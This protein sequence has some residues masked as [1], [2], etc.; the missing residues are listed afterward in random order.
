[1]IAPKKNT[2]NLLRKDF[3]KLALILISGQYGEFKSKAKRKPKESIS[4][5]RQALLI[6]YL[7]SSLLCSRTLSLLC[8]I[9]YLTILVPLG[10]IPMLFS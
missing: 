3:D 10:L 1:M 5:P 4:H 6:K 9:L 2:L 7:A 8:F